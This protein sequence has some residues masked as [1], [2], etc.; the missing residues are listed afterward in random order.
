MEIT[1]ETNPTFSIYMFSFVTDAFII[2]PISIKWQFVT[3]NIHAT[4]YL[5]V[6]LQISDHKNQ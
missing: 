6:L 3:K 4:Q 5:Q 2:I 1:P